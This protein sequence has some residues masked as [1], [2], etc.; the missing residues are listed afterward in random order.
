V[1]VAGSDA[2]EIS[3][4]LGLLL[5]FAAVTGPSPP[6]RFRVYQRTL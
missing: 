4:Y 5:G 6:G 1:T 2:A 3:L